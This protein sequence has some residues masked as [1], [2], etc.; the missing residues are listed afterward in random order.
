MRFIGSMDVYS[1]FI[2]KLRISLKPF[3]ILLHDDVS[4]Q[5]ASDLDQLFNEIKL[6][7]S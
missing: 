2:N 4:S 5:W 6:S 7:L 3:Y 1:K